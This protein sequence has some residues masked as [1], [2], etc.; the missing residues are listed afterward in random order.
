MPRSRMLNPERRRL[1]SQPPAPASAVREDAV[2]EEP[3][4]EDAVRVEPVDRRASTEVRDALVPPDGAAFGFAVGFAV[5]VGFAAVLGF[6]VAFGFAAVV[7][8]A[9]VAG[10][11]GV[12][13]EDASDDDRFG[14]PAAGIV[15]FFTGASRT[16]RRL[17][18]VPIGTPES[19]QVTM[20]RR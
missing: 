3:V 18:G 8:F 1:R 10:C 15:G 6:G 7:R 14:P 19:L 9:V 4:R 2:R 11:F 5:A 20:L 17:S 13:S 12:D 16:R